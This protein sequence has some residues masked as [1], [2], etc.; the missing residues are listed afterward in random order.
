MSSTA[1]P[2]I[3]TGGASPIVW[4]ASS[5]FRMSTCAIAPATLPVPQVMFAP[6]KAGPAAVEVQTMRPLPPIA[7]SPLVPTSTNKAFSVDFSTSQY[8]IPA[9]ISAPTN[10]PIAGRRITS[11]SSPETPNSSADD[12][13]TNS[14]ETGWN[15]NSPNASARSPNSRCSIVVLPAMTM[16]TTAIDSA[17]HNSFIPREISSRTQDC[18]SVSKPSAPFWIRVMT[19]APYC[20]CEFSSV[21]VFR[22]FPVVRST[23]DRAI[24]VVPRSMPI[25]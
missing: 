2:Q 20:R 14:V 23:S 24:V 17:A 6:S 22:T 1:E 4:N 18:N 25:P 15:G 10:A 9:T 5:P 11:Q 7:I 12:S 8:I 3:P 16:R 13:S 21:V 19:S